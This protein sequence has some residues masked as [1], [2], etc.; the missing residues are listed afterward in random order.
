MFKTGMHDQCF[1]EGSSRLLCH[2]VGTPT[3][4]VKVDLKISF[5]KKSELLLDKTFFLETNQC[6]CI[7]QSTPL[8]TFKYEAQI[9]FQKKYN[10]QD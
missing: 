10:T 3:C 2:P 7:T 5:A 8:G 4:L 6:W 1:F 9:V